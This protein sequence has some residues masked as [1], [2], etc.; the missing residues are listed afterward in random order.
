MIIDDFTQLEKM[1]SPPKVP[2]PADFA[3]YPNHAMVMAGIRQR[4]STKAPG[5]LTRGETSSVPSVT[6]AIEPLPVWPPPV[7]SVERRKNSPLVSGRVTLLLHGV[8]R[9]LKSS[10]PSKSSIWP[11]S[12]PASASQPK[13][14]LLISVPPAN[15]RIS[16][17]PLWSPVLPQ[18]SRDGDAA[19]AARGRSEHVVALH[20]FPL[21]RPSKKPRPPSFGRGRRDGGGSRSSTVP[22]TLGIG[23]TCG[24]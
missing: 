15:P 6:A 13:R 12:S 9:R 8:E 2:F 17:A 23:P 4:E 16:S 7:K 10:G 14:S 18:G 21:G 3:P 22:Q 5:K 19:V 1:T 24:F 11:G 20:G